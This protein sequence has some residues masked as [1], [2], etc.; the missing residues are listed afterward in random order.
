MNRERWMNLLLLLTFV[1]VVYYVGSQASTFV[2]GLSAGHERLVEPRVDPYRNLTPVEIGKEVFTTRGCQA[3][4]Q[5][6]LVGG[7]VG[8]SFSNVGARHPADWLSSQLLDP[9]QHVPGNSMPA[10]AFL[11]PRE[12]DGLVAYMGTLNGDRQGPETQGPVKLDPP[13]RFAPAIIDQGQQL[14]AANGCSGCHR[15]GS[16]GGAIGPNLTHEGLRGRSDTW[17]KQHLENPLSV[18]TQGDTQGVSWVMPRYGRLGDKDLDA[19][20]AYLQSLR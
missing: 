2:D 14:F 19:L 6:G 13:Q 15:I 10:Y 1:Y 17:Q 7:T 4:H 18:Y 8:P 9:Q 3:C 20:V 16:E 11:S 5:L 12:R